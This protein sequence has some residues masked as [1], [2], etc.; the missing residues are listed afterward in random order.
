VQLAKTGK[1]DAKASAFLF[2]L[3]DVFRFAER[4]VPFGVMLP[5]VV[6]VAFGK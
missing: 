5:S 6:M 1:A 3:N 4:D 2:W